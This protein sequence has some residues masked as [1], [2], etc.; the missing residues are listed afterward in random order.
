ML[1]QLD[2]FGGATAV[3]PPPLRSSE[4]REQLAWS[5]GDDANRGQLAIVAPE[6]PR[7]PTEPLELRG[8]PLASRCK[9]DRRVRVFRR[10]A[11]W[12]FVFE[13]R[14]VGG[15]RVVQEREPGS[16]WSLGEALHRA[17]VYAELQ[18]AKVYR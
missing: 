14:V 13:V 1:E 15:W 8:L 4:S 5:L 7:K 18:G 6:A 16:R 12:R 9:T 17:G 2:M 10:C 11:G 3:A